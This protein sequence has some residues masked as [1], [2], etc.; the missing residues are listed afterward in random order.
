MSATNVARAGK[1]VK[2]KQNRDSLAHV[3]FLPFTLA[4]C[5]GFEFDWFIGFTICVVCDWTKVMTLVLV[6]RDAFKN[7]LY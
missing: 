3:L 7:H 6:L 5:S 2:S 1:Q 4:V